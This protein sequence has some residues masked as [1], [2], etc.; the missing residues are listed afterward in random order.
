[1]YYIYAN[2]EF[3]INYLIL[4]FSTQAT[5]LVITVI[6]SVFAFPQL[7]ACSTLGLLSSTFGSYEY[8]A[9][10]QAY[11]YHLTTHF[12]EWLN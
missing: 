6:L 11:P 9:S 7:V 8:A 5:I 10:L 12:T 4:C 1:M 2:N 3:R